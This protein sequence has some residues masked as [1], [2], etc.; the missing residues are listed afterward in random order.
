MSNLEELMTELAR[1]SVS[2][3]RALYQRD[4]FASTGEEGSDAPSTSVHICLVC[5]RAAAGKEAQV[6]HK[7]NCELARLQRAQKALWAAWPEL[8]TKKPVP[9]ALPAG[10]A[11]QQGSLNMCNEAFNC[12][13][14]PE[15]GLLSPGQRK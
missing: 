15:L 10:C 11:K 3:K 5:K 4:D 6:R 13:E 7:S 8:F 9:D 2:L 1:S 14:W 12:V